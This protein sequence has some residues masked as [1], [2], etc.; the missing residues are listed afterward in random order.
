M[1]YTEKYVTTTGAG[2][3]DGTSEANAWDWAEMLTNLAAGSRAN[4]K[5]GTYPRTTTA[6]TFSNAG[7]VTNPMAIRGY[8][9]AIGDLE[10]AGRSASAL[11]TTNFPDLTYTTGRLTLPA[12]MVVE[13]M[14]IA[15]APTAAL[16][17]MGVLSSL[18]KCRVVNTHAS[19][20][21]AHGVQ[22]PGSD[23]CFVHDCDVQT[24]SSNAGAAAIYVV[25]STAT[26]IRSRFRAPSGG[27]G[28]K[29]WGTCGIFKCQIL[30][31]GQGISLNSVYCIAD[32][33]SMRNISGA[34]IQRG[35]NNYGFAFTNV[36]AWGSGGSSKFFNGET[37]VRPGVQV[38]NAVGNMGASDSNVGNW[39][40]I[41]A[42]TLTS[43]PFTSSS[44]LSL[45]NTAGGGA[46]CR[47]AGTW[48]F[49]D[50]GAIQHEDAGGAPADS[51]AV[52][53]NGGLV[54]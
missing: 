7:T 44:D 23:A 36:V 3:H 47:A 52:M 5:A 14:D 49:E 46:D 6:D 43:D 39:P 18:R 32:Q 13:C 34:Y 24:D 53:V 16:V 9:S 33:L 10:S 20:A 29:A 17:T 27:I 15:G 26:I 1:A 22:S 54:Q 12:E 19:D 8:N 35:G 50:I 31:A 45:N 25:S 21:G 51:I 4:V 38:N 42:V 37:E 30:D 40:A 41:G 48:D 2:A 28:I 11:V